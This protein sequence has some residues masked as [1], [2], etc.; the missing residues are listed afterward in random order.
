MRDLQAKGRNSGDGGNRTRE[1]FP[2]CSSAPADG[3]SPPFAGDSSQWLYR[4]YDAAGALLYVGVTQCGEERF[5]EH[6]AAK[7]WWPDVDRTTVQTYA[8]RAEVL[9][10]ERQAIYREKPLHNI[11]HARTGRRLYGDEPIPLSEPLTQGAAHAA[12]LDRLSA[13]WYGPK[14]DLVSLSD[15]RERRHAVAGSSR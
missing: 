11:V 15:Y 10:A 1:P 3:E 6:R 14:G 8:T 12:A 4:L 7:S 5:A 9:L 13:V 2:P